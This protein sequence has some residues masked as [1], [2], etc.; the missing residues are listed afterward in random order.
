MAKAKLK[1]TRIGHL[2]PQTKKRGYSARIVT[3]GTS[4]LDDIVAEACRNTTLHRSEAKVALD[5][6]MEIAAEKLKQGHIVDLGPVGRLYPSCSSRWV[7]KV[8]ELKLGNI[9]PTIFYRPATTLS[10]AVKAATLQWTDRQ[11]EEKE[12]KGQDN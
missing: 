12:Q 5:L 6:C 9:T 7:S 11:E 3:S 2:N 10:T 4:T 8:A 1:V